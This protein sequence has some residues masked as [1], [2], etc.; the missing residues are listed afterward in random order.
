MQYTFVDDDVEATPIY[1]CDGKASQPIRPCEN[2][3]LH[4]EHI[5]T[6]IEGRYKQQMKPLVVPAQ[7]SVAN[8]TKIQETWKCM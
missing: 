5:P 1:R 7:G 3:G 2:H 6:W 4:M 8:M